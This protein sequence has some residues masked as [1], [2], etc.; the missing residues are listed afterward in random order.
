MDK[1]TR[2]KIVMFEMYK[3]GTI[4]E[5][6]MDDYKQMWE[7][8]IT[9]WN[10]GEVFFKE[11]NWEKFIDEINCIASNKY[12]WFSNKFDEFFNY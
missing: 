8:L 7:A 3:D 9:Y 5:L 2:I 4:P 12:D 6:D 11:D 1:L 10:L